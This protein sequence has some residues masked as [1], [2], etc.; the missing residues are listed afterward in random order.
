VNLPPPVREYF[1]ARNRFDVE[2]AIAQFEDAAIVKDEDV[3][4]RGRDS[5]RA[6][7]EQTQNKYRPTFEV[8]SAQQSQGNLVVAVI[9]SGTFPGSPL[10]IDHAFEV[11]SG[12]IARL[13]IG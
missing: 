1:E 4:Y 6:W 12:K 8:G 10:Q 13:V 3:E 11:S 9:V 2:T 5:I 7:L